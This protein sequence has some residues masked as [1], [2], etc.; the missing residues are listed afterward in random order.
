MDA[1][2]KKYVDLFRSVK[3]ASAATVDEDGHPRTRIINVLWADDS[4][5]Y[6]VASKGKPFY[7]QMVETG[8]VAISAM[9]PECQS[10]KFLGKCRIVGKE[11]VGKIFDE[12]PGIR[13]VYPGKTRYILDA[14]HV[15]EGQGEWF[16]LLHY[17]ISRETFSYGGVAE[18]HPGFLITDE[19]IEC[20][21]CIETCPQ[22]CIEEGS[23]Y[24]IEW[25]HCLQCGACFET[26]PADAVQRL[27][28]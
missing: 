22:Q 19:C 18:E 20:G 16:D 2:A 21:S 13:E 10:L 7:K 27:H 26:C 12:N 14:F 11:W 24:R 6:L 28:P 8:E 4:G 25:E 9:C 5:M 17:P 3:I 23:P 1:K 15:Y